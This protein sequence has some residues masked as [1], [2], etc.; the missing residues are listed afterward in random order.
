MEAL[1]AEL[2][3]QACVPEASA[4]HEKRCR[5]VHELQRL[6]QEEA[7]PLQ[8]GEEHA[9]VQLS[10]IIG[11]H[12]GIAGSNSHRS[13]PW[14][15]RHAHRQISCSGLIHAEIFPSHLA[16]EQPWLVPAALFLAFVHEPSAIWVVGDLWQLGKIPRLLPIRT[17]RVKSRAPCINF[18]EVTIQVVDVE[19]SQLCV[20]GYLRTCVTHVTFAQK[21]KC[22]LNII[23][24]S[25][26]TSCNLLDVDGMSWSL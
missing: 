5:C 13:L 22:L 26:L 15:V 3:S 20:M 7:C 1:G 18:I 4:E 10:A 24:I 9:H 19:R 17:D 11:K 25:H 2:R 21:L 6:L 12:C 16:K 23:F 8:I 14:I